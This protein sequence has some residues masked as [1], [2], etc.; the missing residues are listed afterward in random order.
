MR[1]LTYEEKPRLQVFTR[2]T[3]FMVQYI[4]NSGRFWQGTGTTQRLAYAAL[5]NLLR[6]YRINLQMQRNSRMF[7]TGGLKNGPDISL[8]PSDYVEPVPPEKWRWMRKIFRM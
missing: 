8:G 4:D 5:E 2:P 7:L 1:K 3:T 6:E